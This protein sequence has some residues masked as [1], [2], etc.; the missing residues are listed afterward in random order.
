MNTQA[1]IPALCL[2]F[3]TLLATPVSAS[4]YPSLPDLPGADIRDQARIIIHLECETP[5]VEVDGQLYVIDRPLEV[6]FAEFD[7]LT[8][9]LV[10]PARAGVFVTEGGTWTDSLLGSP[11][12]EPLAY[13][14]LAEAVEANAHDPLGFEVMMPG[15]PAPTVPDVVVQPT[16]DDPD[17][18]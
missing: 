18:P 10:V 2:A 9:Y 15:Q 17:A 14:L 8:F 13:E 4:K 3:S 11:L 5:L 16:D 7:Q 6:A 12:V 1:I